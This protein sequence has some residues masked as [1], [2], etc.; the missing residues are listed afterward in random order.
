MDE[1]LLQKTNI[2]KI[3]PRF[4]KKGGPNIKELAQKVIDNAAASTKRKQNNA[5]AG[6]H[7]SPPKSSNADSPSADLVGS[8]RAREGESISQPATKRMP[9]TSNPRE[10]GKS[11]VATNGLVKRPGEVAANGK[12]A[13]AAAVRPK[14]N[15]VAPKP[16]SLFG[17]L[18]SASKRP[19]TTNAERAAAAA[20]AKP[21]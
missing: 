3:L 1:E 11:G 2:A 18:S 6:N 7:D 8:K 10:T 19:G 20:A 9:V 13:A 21:T 16:S 17:T 5:K 15:I 12:P 4:T 14:A